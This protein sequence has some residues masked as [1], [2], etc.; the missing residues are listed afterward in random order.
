MSK[1]PYKVAPK[2]DDFIRGEVDLLLKL[3][4]IEEAN[5][6]YAFP[7]VL[8]KKSGGDLRMCIDYRGL[9]KMT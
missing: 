2:E 9:N 8:V 6:D 7:I 1:A 3:G 5:S 4:C